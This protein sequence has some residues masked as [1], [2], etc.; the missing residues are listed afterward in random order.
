MY[1]KSSV[2][3]GSKEIEEEMSS[4]VQEMFMEGGF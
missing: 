1:D 4:F 2:Q 3:V